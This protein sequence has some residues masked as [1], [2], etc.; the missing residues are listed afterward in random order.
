[1]F[2]N[3]TVNG[4]EV[5]V[6]LDIRTSHNFITEGEVKQLGVNI[7]NSGAS[8]EAVNPPAKPIIDIAKL[9]LVQLV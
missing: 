8:L 3:E 5:Q 4:K 9:I 2:I 1:M 7:A 6:M